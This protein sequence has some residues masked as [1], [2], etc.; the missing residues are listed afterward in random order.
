MGNGAQ[1]LEH[2]VCRLPCQSGSTLPTFTVLVDWSIC[3]QF[4]THKKRY[5]KC[6]ESKQYKRKR[7]LNIFLTL[8]IYT[9]V[10]GFGNKSATYV[11]IIYSHLSSVCHPS[12]MHMQDPKVCDCHKH[13]Q[14]TNMR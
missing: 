10:T 1:V 5:T 6:T 8:Y 11:N 4:H 9:I 7:E 2:L 12:S 3:Y 14:T 13:L